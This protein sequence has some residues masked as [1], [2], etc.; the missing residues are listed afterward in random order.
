MVIGIQNKILDGHHKFLFK[1]LIWKETSTFTIEDFVLYS[2]N[3]FEFHLPGNGLY[4]SNGI[5]Q[6]KIRQDII[7]W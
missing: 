5:L 1:Q 2:E 3:H 6:N 7:I 4:P